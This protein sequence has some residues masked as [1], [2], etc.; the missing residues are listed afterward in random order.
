MDFPA[1]PATAAAAPQ[2]LVEG[3]GV[4]PVWTGRNGQNDL[5]VEVDGADTVRKLTPDIGR[6]ARIDARGICVTAVGDGSCD[7]ISRF[8]APSV[9][10][11]E[12]PVT[13]SAHC[14]LALYW[15]E[16]L[17][18]DTLTGCQ[19]SER[20][21]VVRVGVRADRVLITGRAVTV[22]DGT[23]RATP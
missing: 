23:L 10:I 21:G 20:G 18:R 3:L 22:L 12:D 15:A 16:R 1:V 8:F 4:A 5:L 13:G 2:D 17:G 11:P 6:L 19:A 14:M 7:F 9:G